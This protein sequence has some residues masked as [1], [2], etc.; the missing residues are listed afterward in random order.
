MLRRWNGTRIASANGDHISSCLE[1]ANHGS[2]GGTWTNF[3][4]SFSR[5]E[6]VKSSVY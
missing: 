5:A 1:S 6:R 4:N 2:N 3:R